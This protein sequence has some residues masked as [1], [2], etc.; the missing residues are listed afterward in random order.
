M[1]SDGRRGR[2]VCELSSCRNGTRK[3]RLLWLERSGGCPSLCPDTRNTRLAPSKPARMAH[4]QIGANSMLLASGM[5]AQ[6]CVKKARGETVCGN[7]RSAAAVHPNTGRG[8]AAHKNSNGV[9]TTQT[10]N[11]GKAKTKNGMGVAQG[12]NGK[13]CAKGKYEEGC[14]K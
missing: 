12:P 6:D 14:T 4:S 13:T 2:V 9:T 7:G 8:T 10:T 1:G 5:S 3:L 11:G